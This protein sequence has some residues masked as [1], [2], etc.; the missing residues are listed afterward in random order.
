MKGEC[1]SSHILYA[2]R[3]FT[4]RYAEMQHAMQFRV[5]IVV[6]QLDNAF[7]DSKRETGFVGLRNQVCA[8]VE[9]HS[10]EVC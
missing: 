10:L 4:L 1:W 6:E 5:D 7:H 2:A 3:K 8:F 9:Q